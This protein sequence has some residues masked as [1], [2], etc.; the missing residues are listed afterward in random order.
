MAMEGDIY[1][2]FA[3]LNIS[4][5]VNNMQDINEETQQDEFQ[6]ISGNCNLIVNYLPH[7][8]DDLSLRVQK[9]FLWIF[10][11]YTVILMSILCRLYSR[12][13]EKLL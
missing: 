5:P 7:D 2:Q 11:L 1:A 6:D 12:S 9:I 13:S 4:D 10:F 3:T 8:I